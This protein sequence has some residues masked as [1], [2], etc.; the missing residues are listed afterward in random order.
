[1]QETHSTPSDENKWITEWGGDLIFSHGTSNSTGVIIGFSSNFNHNIGKIT[2]DKNGRVLIAD[3]STDTRSYTI[4]NFYNSNSESEQLDSIASLNDLIDDHIS[5][6]DRNFILSGDMNIFFDTNLDTHG[7][8][9]SLKK[10][11]L[12]ALINLLEKI[13]VCDIFRIRHPDTKRF[14]FRQKNRNKALIHRRL[15]YIFLSN[16]LQE[17][18]KKSIF[19]LPFVVIILLYFCP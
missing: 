10:K 9:P 11:S 14:T 13:D 6:G 7:G 15:D 19:Y 5:D 3:F 8:Q 1:M 2:R 12:S 18:A 4:V 17:F 16:S